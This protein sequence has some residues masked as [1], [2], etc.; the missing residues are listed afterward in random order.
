MSEVC[1]RFAKAVFDLP[2]SSFQVEALTQREK[3][4][5]ELLALGYPN[6]VIAEKL[7]ISINTIKYHLKTIFSKFGVNNRIQANLIYAQTK[8]QFDD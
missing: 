5:M 1:N 8:V 7:S 2:L 4:I 6:K 3:N